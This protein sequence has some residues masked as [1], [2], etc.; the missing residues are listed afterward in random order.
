V[1]AHAAVQ[2]VRPRRSANRLR[3]SRVISSGATEQRTVTHV[4]GCRTGKLEPSSSPA[5]LLLTI[6]AFTLAHSLTLA[7]STPGLLTLRP[8]P[9]EATIALSIMLVASEALRGC[10]SAR[11]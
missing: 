6:A 2:P 1:R 7:S 3:A 11:R 5:R 9:V 10:A 8:L 4:D